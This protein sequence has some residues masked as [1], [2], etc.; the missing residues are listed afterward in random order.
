MNCTTGHFVSVQ[1]PLEARVPGSYV[2][3]GWGLLLVRELLRRAGLET[4]ISERLSDDSRL[5]LDTESRLAGLLDRRSMVGSR[6]M[7]S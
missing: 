2:S 4:R 1:R 7:K 3:S 5:R 6:P